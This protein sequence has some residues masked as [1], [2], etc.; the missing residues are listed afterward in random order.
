MAP[1]LTRLFAALKKGGALFNW[2]HIAGPVA[3]ILP[4]YPGLG[5]DI[6]N[7]DYEV[8]PQAEFNSC[9]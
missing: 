3:P 5:V 9:S 2:L 6:A 4:L 1:R 8:D 7:F